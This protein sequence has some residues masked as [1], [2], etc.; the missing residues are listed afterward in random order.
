MDAAAEPGSRAPQDLGPLWRSIG[1]GSA[2]FAFLNFTLPIYGRE[3][4]ASAF[5]IGA[6]FAVFTG[7]LML[8]RPIVGWALDHYGRRRFFLAALWFYAVAMGVF[9]QS[10]A[11]EGLLLARAIQGL[12]A[13]FMW[14]SARTMVADWTREAERGAAMGRVTE[15]SARGSIYGGFF[16]FTL[17]GFL[18]LP[19]AWPLAF[20]GYA[21]LALLGWLLAAR[22]LAESSAAVSPAATD[23]FS[24]SPPLR[25]LAAV[26]FLIGF[27]NALLGPV[28]LIYLEDKFAVEPHIL[29]LVF[30]LSGVVY[31]TLPSRAGR[32]SDRL[33]RT[34][35]MALG[36]AV[37][38]VL[39]LLVPYTSLAWLVALYAAMAAGWCLVIPARDAWTGDLA[40]SHQRG[41]TYGA[42]EFCGAAG[43]AVGP[44][45][46]GALYDGVSQ[47]SPFFLTSALLIATAAGV[48]MAGGRRGAALTG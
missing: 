23:S 35:T 1:F 28:Y 10:T 32:L 29:A 33:G 15:S 18:P 4:G 37:V 24:W 38:A 30:A 34:S 2:A 39:T 19:I 45:V 25:R 26:V 44:L 14:I 16:G 13:A 12:G 46:G 3:L 40:G 17:L 6:T 20:A 5:Q 41:R 47:V 8:G 36:L 27:G 7:A 31:A 48:W 22:T 9:S 42:I 11:I 43:G 21:M